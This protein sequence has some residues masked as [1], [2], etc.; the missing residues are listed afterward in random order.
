MS[1]GAYAI[2][3][4][5]VCS[6]RSRQGCPNC[7]G[8][9]GYKNVPACLA[10]PNGTVIGTQLPLTPEITGWAMAGSEYYFY[11][12]DAAPNSDTVEA[13]ATSNMQRRARIEIVL[14]ARPEMLSA[15]EQLL[16]IEGLGSES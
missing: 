14:Q 6:H 11:G 5:P 13:I 1:Y 8:A 3:D 2:P 4:C 7:G 9:M 10:C 15:V 12:T 16:A